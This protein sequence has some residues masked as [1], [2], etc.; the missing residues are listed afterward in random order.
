MCCRCNNRRRKTNSD[1][2]RGRRNGADV[3]IYPTE[4]EH[5]VEVLTPWEKELEMLEDW[6]NNPEPVDD[7]HEQT[8]MQILGE[9]HSI[10]FLR[11]FSQEAEQMMTAALKPATEDESEFQSEEQLGEAGDE[12]TEELAEASLSKEEAEKQLS[13]ETAEMEF[14]VGWQ[15]KATRRWRKNKGD[16]DDPP[17]DKEECNRTSSIKRANH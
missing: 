4:E 17:I 7:C 8:V 2:H 6:L 9:E 15:A 13:N 5:A 10:E 14:A 3:D 16:Q 12:P 11:N 1:C